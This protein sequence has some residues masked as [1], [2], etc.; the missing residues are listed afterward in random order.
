MADGS[1][2]TTVGISTNSNNIQ[3]TWSVTANGASAYRFTGPGNDGVDDNPDLYLVR[4]QRYRFINNS[5]GSHPFQIRSV[6][7]GSAYSAGV[8]NNG[9]AS[10]NI[11]FNVQHDA[12]SRLYYQC[13]AHS[14]MVGNIYITGGGQWQ[15]T[16]VAASGT[17]E[18]Y[19]DYNVGIGTDNPA[20]KLSHLN[21]N[22]W[23]L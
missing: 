2:S 13:T 19:T 17:P 16:S 7:G 9:A 15:N 20:A 22:N 21:Y 4:G 3:A 5:G 14:G 23:K 10:G 12:P 18:I 8:T 11:E 1:V 6:V